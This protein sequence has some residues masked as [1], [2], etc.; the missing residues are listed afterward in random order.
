M[1]PNNRAKLVP[2]VWRSGPLAQNGPDGQPDMPVMLSFSWRFG[3]TLGAVDVETRNS[4]HLQPSYFP[5]TYG[6]H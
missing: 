4:W 2:T 3:G 5:L 6:S 1:W